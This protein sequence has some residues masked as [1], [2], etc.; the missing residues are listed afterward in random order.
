MGL[1][2]DIDE[3]TKNWQKS[4]WRIKIFLLISLFNLMAPGVANAAYGFF[5]SPLTGHDGLSV[6]ISFLQMHRFSEFNTMNTKIAGHI[7]INNV[8]LDSFHS[9]AGP[10]PVVRV[11]D[12]WIDL[13]GL[14]RSRSHDKIWSKKGPKNGKEKVHPGRD[15]PTFANS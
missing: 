3:V 15:H 14:N 7:L 13:P 9:D 5:C 2:A 8:I 6:S 11:D 12:Q 4:P 1:K 10:V